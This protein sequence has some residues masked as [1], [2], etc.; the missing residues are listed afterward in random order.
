MLCMDISS[1][2]C[3]YGLHVMPHTTMNLFWV[4]EACVAPN[5]YLKDATYADKIIATILFWL[6]LM[7]ELA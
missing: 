6:S 1:C 3:K 7:L 5:L 2:E 4:H